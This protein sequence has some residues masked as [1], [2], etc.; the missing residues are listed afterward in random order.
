MIPS[1]SEIPK[2]KSIN[3][4]YSL[5]YQLQQYPTTQHYPVLIAIFKTENF[6][7]CAVTQGKQDISVYR[8]HNSL[9]KKANENQN[10]SRRS[11]FVAQSLLR[12]N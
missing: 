8:I 3:F 9:T 12:N 7:V 6:A 1:K 10:T 2:Q 4:K 11:I 5:I